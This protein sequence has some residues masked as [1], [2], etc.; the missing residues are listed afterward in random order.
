MAKTKLGAGNVEIELDGESV[1]L[2]PTLKAA[3]TISRQAGGIMGAV[4]SISRFDVDVLTTVIALGLGRDVKD[5]AEPVWRTGVSTLAPKAIQFLTVLANG[6]RP[7][8][9]GGGEEEADPQ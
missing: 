2:R 1:V 3:Q 5:T 6:G 4:Q 9:E 7:P 8:E